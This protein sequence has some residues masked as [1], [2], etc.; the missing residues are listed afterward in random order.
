[1]VLEQTEV[2]NCYLLWRD[3]GSASVPTGYP[4]KLCKLLKHLCCGDIA[5]PEPSAFVLLNLSPLPWRT[6]IFI[7][8]VDLQEMCSSATSNPISQ[9]VQE[10]QA[11][12]L[13]NAPMAPIS[14]LAHRPT[15]TKIPQE[16]K[17]VGRPCSCLRHLCQQCGVSSLGYSTGPVRWSLMT[18]W[19]WCRVT[20][21]TGT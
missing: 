19:G 21:L 9:V 6:C 11:A 20:S 10:S 14:P 3:R 2:C 5:F 4:G 13:H 16:K 8:P 1:M 7:F 12:V 17:I 18:K 15:T